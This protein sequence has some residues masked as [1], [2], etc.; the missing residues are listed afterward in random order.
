MHMYRDQP[1]DGEF[2]GQTYHINYIYMT[3]ILTVPGTLYN[4]AYR[5]PSSSSFYQALHT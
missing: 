3:R 5:L 4:N 1:Q 2:Q